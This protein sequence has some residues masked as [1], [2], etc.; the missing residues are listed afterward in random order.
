M[1]AMLI[2]LLNEVARA[3]FVG[4]DPKVWRRELLNAVNHAVEIDGEDAV[5][6]L[7]NSAVRAD[8]DLARAL[9]EG[10]AERWFPYARN[11]LIT[12]ARDVASQDLRELCQEL[13]RQHDRST[14]TRAF[15]DLVPALA[16]RLR[17]LVGPVN[18]AGVSGSPCVA[19]DPDGDLVD[20]G[21][22]GPAG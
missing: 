10:L 21:Q 12:L 9:I 19:H 1:S 2:D 6:Q 16:Q 18:S 17:D 11:S 15:P 14:G 5:R 13:V 3:P 4:I 22:R 8:P 20:H 7:L